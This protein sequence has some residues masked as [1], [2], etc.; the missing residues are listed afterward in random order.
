MVHAALVQ[1]LPPLQGKHRQTQPCL[2][3][4]LDGQIDK[5]ERT[6]LSGQHWDPA[7]TE[8]LQGTSQHSAT[9]SR[10][11][12]SQ[13]TW[14]ELWDTDTPRHPS[15]PLPGHGEATSRTS[16]CVV[17]STVALSTRAR[18][19]KDSREV[20]LYNSAIA[21]SYTK[22]QACTWGMDHH[23]IITLP[24]SSTVILQS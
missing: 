19:Y 14:A 10:T 1:Q 16:S 4:L 21:L 9:S 12:G 22:V 15:M 23:L 17:T 3:L 13:W 6:V 18:K 8:S 2:T 7:H 24:L 20:A 5:L 11:V